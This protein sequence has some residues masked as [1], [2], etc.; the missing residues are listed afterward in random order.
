[1]SVCEVI[2]AERDLRGHNRTFP[3][4]RLHSNLPKL[5]FLL[6]SLHLTPLL[7]PDVR[8]DTVSHAH[9]IQA[10]SMLFELSSSDSEVAS[11]NSNAIRLKVGQ[12]N[13]AQQ[14]RGCVSVKDGD[15]GR[16]E[17]L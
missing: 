12:A 17:I 10:V 15:P 13:R 9:A 7:T 11:G 1:M 2:A 14:G 3:R 16:T 8:I 5:R 6:Q 4:L